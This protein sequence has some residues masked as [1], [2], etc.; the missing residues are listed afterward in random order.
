M[1]DHSHAVGVH[2]LVRLQIIHGAAQSPR[3]GPNRS[4]AVNRRLRLAGTQIESANSLPNA[5]LEIGFDIAVIRC[6]QPVATGENLLQLPLART[7]PSRFFRR[8]MVNH[9]PACTP[10]PIRVDGDS[11]V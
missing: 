11:R 4:P 10:H 8:V 3:P 7:S 1:P 2:I 5:A 6:S 9:T